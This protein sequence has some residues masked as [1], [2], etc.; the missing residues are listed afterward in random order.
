MLHG[1]QEWEQVRAHDDGEPLGQVPVP[2]VGAVE[3]R[4]VMEDVELQ[5]VVVDIHPLAVEEAVNERREEQDD[6]SVTEDNRVVSFIH[7]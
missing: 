1:E 2:R 4:H 3:A 5:E 6:E 7:I